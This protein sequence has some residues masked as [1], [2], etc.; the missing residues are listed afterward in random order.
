MNPEQSEREGAVVW[1]QKNS[2]EHLCPEIKA[3][4]NRLQGSFNEILAK[5]GERAHLAPLGK[6][7]V[8]DGRVHRGLEK[9]P[10][11]RSE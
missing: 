3:L 8:T 4:E 5:K 2:W 10:N 11:T 1:T 9:D 6:L 7:E